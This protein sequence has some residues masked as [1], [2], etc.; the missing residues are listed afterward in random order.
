MVKHFLLFRERGCLR[1]SVSSVL[2]VML[3]FHT[4]LGIAACNFETIEISLQAS[5]K[6]VEEILQEIGKQSGFTLEYNEFESLGKKKS[7][8]L[9]KAPFLQ[10]VNRVL[11][12]ENYSVTCNEKE[13]S[14]TLV[15]LGADATRKHSG[16]ANKQI[17]SS[18]AQETDS[19][20]GLEDAWEDYKKNPPAVS[21]TPPVRDDSHP[22]QPLEDAWED[23]RKNPPT[24]STT[25]PVR[26]ESDPLQPLEDAWE[27]YNKNPPTVSTTPPV[28]DESHPLQGLEDAWD[29]Y[30]KNPPTI[31]TAPSVRDDSDPLQGLEDAWED[32]RKNPPGDSSVAPVSPPVPGGPD[33][34]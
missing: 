30:K 10:S 34:L 32:Y 31:S 33:P 5:N 23:Y 6:S 1:Y 28:R 26:D 17:P 13:H 9:E 4:N 25:P 16:I 15:V 12:N 22:L 27:D 20:Q 21:T 11:K 3:L 2:L 19:L 8:I 29:D 7:I 18:K 14:V 24:V